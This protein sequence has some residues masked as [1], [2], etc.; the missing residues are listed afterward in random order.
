M[1][2]DETI[3]IASLNCL[4]WYLL[5]VVPQGRVCRHVQLREAEAAAEFCTAAKDNPGMVWFTGR[6]LTTALSSGLHI[7]IYNRSSVVYCGSGWLK[8]RLF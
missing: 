1:S 3:C 6:C 8:Q 7:K 2:T 5:L 4:T